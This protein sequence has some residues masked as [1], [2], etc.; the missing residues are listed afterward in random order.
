MRLV[1]KLSVIVAIGVLLHG[2]I[3][4]YE[5]EIDE[6]RFV[7]RTLMTSWGTGAVDTVELMD[8]AVALRD[9]Q[10]ARYHRRV[11]AA[12]G[13]GGEAGTLVAIDSTNATTRPGW[14]RDA[15]DADELALALNMVTELTM[16]PTDR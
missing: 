11:A 2:W 5:S 8:E 4:R 16:P 3:Q 6:A 7:L 12:G 9:R 1:W 13:T 15:S 10:W 14:E